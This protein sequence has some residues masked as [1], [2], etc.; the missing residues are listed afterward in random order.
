MSIEMNKPLKA[1]FPNIVAGIESEFT[2][3]VNIF[4]QELLK[5]KV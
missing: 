5:I 1:E 3:L 2:G 4:N